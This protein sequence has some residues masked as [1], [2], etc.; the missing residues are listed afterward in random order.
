MALLPSLSD[1]EI[2]IESGRSADGSARPGTLRILERSPERL[3][4]ETECPDL[5]WLFVLRGFWMHRTVRLDGRELATF[6]AQLAFSA[7]PVP[8]GKHRVD[9]KERVPG[10]RVS[11]WGP[12]LYLIAIAAA[13]LLEPRGPA[14]PQRPAGGE[15]TR[16]P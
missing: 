2:V 7:L 8:A 10:G 5:M 15:E 14:L 13:A 9:W 11:R 12:L 3:R 16:I 1:G 6:P 4:L